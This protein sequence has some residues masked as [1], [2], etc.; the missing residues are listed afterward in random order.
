MAEN[1][2]TG[3][4]WTH[5]P[6]YRG[7]TWNPSVG[8][9]VLTPGCKRCYAMRMAA[10]LEAMGSA[11]YAGLT[12][13]TSSGAVWNGVVRLDERSLGIPLRQ[14]SP[15]CYFVNSMSDLF[16]E[17]LSWSDIGRVF[18]VMERCPQ[19]VFQ[20]LT[21]RHERMERLCSLRFFAGKPP[22]SNI[23]LGV[24]VEDQKRADERIPA[25]L[26]TPA[27]VRFLSCEPLLGSI[28]LR[29]LRYGTFDA[30]TGCGDRERLGAWGETPSID[31]V[32]AGA[33]SGAGAR[34]CSVAWIRSIRD[35]CAG[36]R[37]PFYYKQYATLAGK[38]I[39]TPVLD[40]RR[41]TEFPTTETSHGR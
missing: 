30:M 41:W 18:D 34:R 10:R 39:P 38:K 28:D 1:Q 17:A 37:V 21:K 4:Q 36:A 12:R 5:L 22:A 33:E 27:A 16:H 13:L 32:I 40:G 25:L 11:K 6:G 2:G 35:Q 24:S 14:K 7:E 8:C 3:I 9:S 15:R 29:N 26:R 20:I 31:W 19:H 23:W